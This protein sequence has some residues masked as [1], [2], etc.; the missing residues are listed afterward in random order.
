MLDGAVTGSFL[1]GEL[2]VAGL[3]LS[4][5][6]D[7]ILDPKELLEEELYGNRSTLIMGS[8]IADIQ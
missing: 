8:P 7:D 3:L 6:V 4:D 2:P 1:V 5:F